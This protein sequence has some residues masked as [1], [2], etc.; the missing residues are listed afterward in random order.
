MTRKLP[1]MFLW[2][3][4]LVMSISFHLIAQVQ[5]A[6]KGLPNAIPFHLVAKLIVV[7]ANAG[8]QTG[9]F[10]L[11]TGSPEL[12]LNAAWF[13]AFQNKTSIDDITGHTTVFKARYV[14][15]TLG[16]IHIK[17]KKAFVADLRHLE[18]SRKIPILGIIGYS[19]LKNLEIL[20][21]YK[22]KKIWLLPTG[23]KQKQS[24]ERYPPTDVFSFYLKG[25]L[26]VINCAIGE[27]QLRVILDTGAGINVL[28]F[29]WK[30]LLAAN[31]SQEKLTHVKSFNKHS[32]TSTSA[33]VA[34]FSLG[35]ILYPPMRTFFSESNDLKLRNIEGI[36][37]YEF[38]KQHLVSINF[39]RKELRI[40]REEVM[41]EIK[42]LSVYLEGVGKI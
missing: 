40:W 42:P 27:H 26:P 2:S 19:V 41:K 5:T 15:F 32:V 35:E 3:I 33:L 34:N 37:G 22:F 21:D 36:L 29:K 16:N 4:V 38:L 31:I 10:I 18:R 11:D 28:K 6:G 1:V 9:L 24:M 23:K 7:E 12:V 17:K 8:N 39:P 13:K 25:H 30:E 20:L 14:S